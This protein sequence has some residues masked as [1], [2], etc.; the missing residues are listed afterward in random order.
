M[1]RVAFVIGHTK[2]N[3]GAYSSYFELREYDFWKQFECELKEVGDVF[4]HNCLIYGY[5]SRQR[6]MGMKTKDYDIV[7]E[8]HFNSFNGTTQ[9]C[10]ALYY[11]TNEIT[12][13]ISNKFCSE[14]SSLSDGNNRGSKSL[15][16]NNQRGFGFVYYQKTNAVI[17]EPFFGDNYT[18]CR[19]FEIN[20]FINAIK[21][22]II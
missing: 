13:E 10:E 7:F 14:Y 8:V 1:M 4:Y 22:A 20:N 3:K 5:N 2:I 17:L 15:S 9:G 18:D 6:A 19:K 21:K 16:N 12:K 11:H